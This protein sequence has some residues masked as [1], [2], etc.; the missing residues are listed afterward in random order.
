MMRLLNNH[1]EDGLDMKI[2]TL[3]IDLAK[4]IFHLFAVSKQGRFVKKKMLKRK[5]LLSYIAR[6][7]PCTIVMESCGSSNYWSREFIKLGHQVKLIAPQFVSPYRKGNKNDFN[8]AEAIAEAAQRPNMRFVPI[9]SIEQQDTQI[10][11]R[12]RERLKGQRTALINQTRGL[13]AEYGIVIKLGVCAFKKELPL[14]LEDEENQLTA[15]SREL[16][17]ELRKEFI[18]LDDR[19][20]TFEARMIQEN[21]TIPTCKKLV[22]VLGIGAVTASASYASAGD[23]KEFENGRHF[24]ACLGLVPRQHSSG[25]KNNLLGISKRGNTYLRTLFIHCARS[26]LSHSE[27]KTDKFSLWAN[28]LKERSGFNKACVAVANKLAR[29]AWVMMATDA[30]FRIVK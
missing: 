14:I 5:Q 28:K 25:G 1:L 15:V 12:I 19:Y 10:L 9:K 7:D 24:S 11:H 22:T 16:F 30:E 3:G 18:K 29:M 4:N 20:K 21:T 13:L 27:K 23:G 6:L 8:D 17:S 2:H 26:V